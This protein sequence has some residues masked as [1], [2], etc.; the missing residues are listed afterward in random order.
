MALP[1]VVRRSDLLGTLAGQSP[2]WPCAID[3]QTLRFDV[4]RS[5]CVRNHCL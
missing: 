4:R 5:R 1:R 2:D 3:S